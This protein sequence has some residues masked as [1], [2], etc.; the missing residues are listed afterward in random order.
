MISAYNLRYLVIVIKESN[1]HDAKIFLVKF[2]NFGIVRKKSEQFAFHQNI[3]RQGWD[4]ELLKKA[5]GDRVV[6]NGLN[7]WNCNCWTRK[8]TLEKPV[9]CCC[10]DFLQFFEV[11]FHRSQ[12]GLDRMWVN[13]KR[14]ITQHFDLKFESWTRPPQRGF[15]AKRPLWDVGWSV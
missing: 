3:G 12:S 1:F 14:A 10:Y 9:K 6:N 2:A 5:G 4:L 15:L 7:K 8:S 13:L 11:G